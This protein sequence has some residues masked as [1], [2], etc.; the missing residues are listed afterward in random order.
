M[1]HTVDYAHGTSREFGRSDIK[2]LIHLVGLM[3]AFTVKLYAAWG[4]E[5]C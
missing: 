4:S 5:F 3:N 2:V 1:N